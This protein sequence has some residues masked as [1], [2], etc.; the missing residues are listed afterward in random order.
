MTLQA[1]MNCAIVEVPLLPAHKKRLFKPLTLTN[2]D[3]VVYTP[4]PKIKLYKPR[5]TRS[6][7]QLLEAVQDVEKVL[8]EG[9]EEEEGEGEKKENYSCSSSKCTTKVNQTPTRN[10]SKI[11]GKAFPIVVDRP[12]SKT[13]G[14]LSSS[15]TVSTSQPRSVTSTHTFIKQDAM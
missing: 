5:L 6:R 3:D 2:Y 13:F 7:S 11:I 9:K 8:L 12:F 15:T 10:V 1:L 14:S 4:T